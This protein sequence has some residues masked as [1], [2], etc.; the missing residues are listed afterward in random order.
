MLFHN[1]DT[2][3]N[4]AHDG[5]IH[6]VARRTM[7]YMARIFDVPAYFRMQSRCES[8]VSRP[9]VLALQVDDNFIEGQQRHLPAE[10][11]RK[12]SGGG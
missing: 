10:Y 9:F 1:P 6:E 8:P 12:H 5:C 7:G 3:E 4:R 2:G 11:I